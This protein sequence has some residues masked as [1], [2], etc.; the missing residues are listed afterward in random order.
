[1]FKKEATFTGSFDHDCQEKSV[2][3]TLLTMVS[4][5]LD[6]ANIRSQ[7]GGGVSQAALAQHSCCT[8][9]ALSVEEM[10]VL[11]F[12]TTKNRETPLAIYVG[13]TVHAMTRKRGLVDRLFQLGLSI[14][15]DRVM[16][17][18]MGN[19]VCEQYH[20]DQ[21]ICPPNIRQGLFTT[22]AIDNIDH[23]PSSTTA[24]DS[25][26]GTGI[27][28]FQ[29]P[30]PQNCGTD[31]REHGIL[32]QSPSTRTLSELPESYT[33]VPPLVLPTKDPAIPNTDGAVKS[34]GKVLPK[35]LDEEFE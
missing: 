17:T 5:I 26:H 10:E 1:M 6:G 2:L 27:S 30:T 20:R 19:R 22:A 18:T 11:L 29:H 7:S 13:L 33:S 16:S 28:L 24:S 23:N 12:I 9:I 21:A 8:T 15:Y 14:S 3:Q 32:E 4:M 34:D 31:R 25:F 35:A